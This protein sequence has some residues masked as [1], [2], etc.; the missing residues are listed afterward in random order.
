MLACTLLRRRSG[1]LGPRGPYQGSLG[2]SAPLLWKIEPARATR[3]M[4]ASPAAT[5]MRFL[6]HPCGLKAGPSHFYSVRP[7]TLLQRRPFTGVT[8]K[9]QPTP[10]M[11]RMS[12]RAPP[13][14]HR[15]TKPAEALNDRHPM[16]YGGL[17]LS[18][19][20][21]GLPPPPA[22]AAGRPGGEMKCCLMTVSDVLSHDA[23]DDDVRQP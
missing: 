20:H 18:P 9:Q 15:T 3:M 7:C 10:K 14:R 22:A 1:A 13:D 4:D 16:T 21:T 17:L 5:K 2:C 6:G 11:H 8:I 23:G 19:L 12:R